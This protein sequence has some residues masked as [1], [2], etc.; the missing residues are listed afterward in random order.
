MTEMTHTDEDYIACGEEYLS[1]GERVLELWKRTDDMRAELIIE[2]ESLLKCKK[3]MERGRAMHTYEHQKRCCLK[4]K[5][6]I[7]RDALVNEINHKLKYANDENVIFEEKTTVSLPASV[8]NILHLSE[9]VSRLKERRSALLD[10]E[11]L[12]LFPDE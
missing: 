11:K 1:V 4:L 5:L 6:E 9:V 3:K 7:K 12:R 10:E 2:M 8:K